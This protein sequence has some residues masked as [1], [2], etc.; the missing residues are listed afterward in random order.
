MRHRSDRCRHPLLQM[1]HQ[2]HWQSVEQRRPALLT[3]EKQPPRDVL[4]S[5]KHQI[6]KASGRMAVSRLSQDQGVLSIVPQNRREGARLRQYAAP[7]IFLL[8]WLSLRIPPP[9]MVL[10]RQCPVQQLIKV[11]NLYIQP[12]QPYPVFQLD[13]APR[14]ARN[15]S[16]GPRFSDV[17]HFSR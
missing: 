8:T 1:E 6:H 16:I 11:Y 5:H 12:T 2:I 9:D 10:N 3:L 13:H 4:Y 7:G 14:A 17:R 15:E